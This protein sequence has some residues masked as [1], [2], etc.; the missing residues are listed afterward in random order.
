VGVAE[1]PCPDGGGAVQPD[2]GPRPRRIATLVDW[3]F[4][5]RWLTFDEACRLSG[6]DPETLREII[7]VDGVDL[8]NEGRIERQSLWDF[9]EAALELEYWDRGDVWADLVDR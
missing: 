3:A 1:T 2:S 5:P 6:R 7:A 8:D 4:A 9:L